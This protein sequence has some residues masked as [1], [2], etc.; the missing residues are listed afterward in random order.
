MSLIRLGHAGQDTTANAMTWM[1]KYVDENEEVL[2]K[3]M[4]SQFSYICI[5]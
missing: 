4:V 5:Y 2:N 3:L 1:I